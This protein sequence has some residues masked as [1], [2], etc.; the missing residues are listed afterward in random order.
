LTA[1]IV[2]PSNPSVVRKAF[3]MLACFG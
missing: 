1:E 2:R 3:W